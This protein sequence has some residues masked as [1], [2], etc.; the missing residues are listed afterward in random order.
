MAKRA[1]ILFLFT[2]VGG[3]VVRTW[4]LDRNGQSLP[5]VAMA[6]MIDEVHFSD[7]P[8]EAALA[9]LSRKAGVKID[10][11][12]AQLE[13]IGVFRTTPV[14]LRLFDLPVETILRTLLD[15]V[16]HIDPGEA[17][18]TRGPDA[19]SVTT[20]HAMDR[21]VELRMYDVGRIA[22][23]FGIPADAR[24][25]K[26]SAEY[27]ERVL[28]VEALVGPTVWDR[29]M[30]SDSAMIEW[31]GRLFVREGRLAH[32]AIERALRKLER[33]EDATPQ[34]RP[35]IGPFPSLHDE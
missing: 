4:L 27:K 8:L 11:D 1:F 13:Q 16:P 5:V 20:A 7:M 9:E 14:T 2:I 22:E 29:H 31:R 32:Q 30:D 3:L 23:R 12:W 19:I 24:L 21:Q 10:I 6:R 15:Q 35:V 25:A 26:D 17:D 34:L 33:M 28:G 18:F